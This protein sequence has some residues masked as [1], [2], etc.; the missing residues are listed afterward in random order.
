M[1][2][3]TRR[4]PLA[5]LSVLALAIGSTTAA[6][7]EDSQE[8]DASTLPTVEVTAAQSGA[9]NELEVEPQVGKLAVPIEEQPFALS[10]VDQQQIEE[11]G[12][13]NLQEALQYSSGVQ[14]GNFGYDTRIDSASVRGVSPALYLDG[15]RQIYG[16]YN[17]VRTNTFALESVEVMKGPSSV[18]YGQGGLGGVVN[19]VSKRPQA[20]Q[21]GELWAQYGSYN[22]K[23][24]AAD[25]TGPLNEEGSLLYRIIGLYRDSDTQVDHV[26]DNGYVISPSLTWRPNDD[27]SLTLLINRQENTGQVSAQFLPQAGTLDQ[28]PEGYFG[29]ETFAGEPDWDRYDRE[30]TEATLFFDQRLNASWSF[31]ATARYTQSS[32]ETRE[33]WPS[34]P[35]TMVGDEYA[36]TLY[37]SDTATQ[38]FNIDNRLSGSFDFAGTEHQLITGL[39]YQDALWETDNYFYGYGQGSTLDLYDPEYGTVNEG[40]ITPSD[41]DDNAIKQLGIYVADQIELNA[42]AL[43]VGLRH[44]WAENR[45][46]AVSGDDTVSDE[47]ETTG[48]AGLMYH[49]G[50]GI[51]PYV[52]YAQSFEMNLGTDG[53]DGT[54]DPTRGEQTE[55]GVKYLSADRSLSVTAAAFH[56]SEEDRVQQGTT[57]G[58]VSQVGSIINGWEMQLNK[59]WARVE[60]Q[61]AYTSLDATNES[62]DT[63]L[64]YVAEQVGSWWNNLFLGDAWRLGAGVRYIGDSVGSGGGPKIPAVTLYDAS[65]SY[66]WNNWDVSVDGKNLADEEYISWCRSEGND[67]GYG[68]RRN[69]TANL[70]YRF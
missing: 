58:G 45:E 41:R 6:L 14:G 46:L 29:S 28:G 38:I 60:T 43:S 5:T 31:G 36:R 52:S 3:V 66:A 2:D 64:P 37:T 27:T 44:D 22:R 40:V 12:A 61:L 30:K 69:L 15:L 10:V 34:I 21:A 55:A 51:A 42:W 62:D 67:C 26:E 56:I 1:L 35:A 65:V 50:N 54:L 20:E 17:S 16:S 7:A 23:Q 11:T 59:R 39:D 63:R 18:L 13:K 68:E 25:L 57:P 33:H 24:I 47:S 48:R 8:N 49:F 32:A 19:S 70:R 9:G 53:Q 4:Q